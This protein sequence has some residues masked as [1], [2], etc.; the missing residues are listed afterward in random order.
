MLHPP[1]TA[2]PTALPLP[3]ATLAPITVFISGA[4]QQPGLYAL[5]ADARVGDALTLAGGLIATAN[6]ALINQAEKLWDGAQVHVPDSAAPAEQ[7]VA[8]QP[9]VGVSG[10]PAPVSLAGGAMTG[11][12]AG[13][14]N[15]NTATVAELETL[16]GIGPSKAAAII[17]NRPYATV[18]ELDKV[19]GIGFSTIEQ[20]RAMATAP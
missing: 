16:P 17:A 4:V 3:T 13:S 1:P 19:P 20:L 6:A 11:G 9:P 10:D 14:V 8:A 7:M 18:D 15:I 12:A 2:A 5:P